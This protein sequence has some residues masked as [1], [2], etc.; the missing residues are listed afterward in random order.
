MNN[1][2]PTFT[3][4]GHPNKGK[5]S[6]VATLAQTDA[7]EISQRS[8]TTEQAHVY[9]I[10][11]PQGNLRLIDTPGFQRPY[12]ALQWLKSH[13]DNASSRAKTV[14][15]FIH[16]ETCMRLFPDEV[17]L[18]T[19]I[20]NG[21]V[22]I[23]VVDGS[24]PYG[25][26]YEFEMEIL[27]WTG[28]PSMA[29][30]NPIENE[31]HIH[32]WQDALNQYFKRVKIFNPMTAEFE[33]QVE[34][35]SIFA[36]LDDRWHT[37]LINIG[38]GLTERRKQKIAQCVA[39]L[40]QL[41]LDVCYYSV[42][43]KTINE[44]QASSITPGLKGQWEYWIKKREQDAFDGVLRIYQHHRSTLNIDQLALPPDLFDQ[45]KWYLWGLNKKQ[46][47][48]ASALA[49]AMTGATIDAATAGHSFMLGAIGGG[50]LGA[51]GSFF[52]SDKIADVS[53]KGMKVG[54]NTAIYGPVRH[55]NFPYVIL[56]R[57]IFFQQQVSSLNHANRSA[58][59][60]TAT[61]FQ[62]HIEQL[63]KSDRKELAVACARLA[64]QQTVKNLD[65]ILMTLMNIG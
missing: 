61:D 16:N 5:S 34:L 36:H 24:R 31:D 3:V 8:G 33:K 42:E 15:Q 6:I 40:E 10:T 25:A 30:I 7:I 46:L 27:R 41:L 14:E 32:E 20:V 2:S 51:G 19:P 4:V 23:Y 55:K 45:D 59:N 43:Q 64:K 35:L 53:I 22:I 37:Q 1:S 21:S 48:A 9:E 13:A 39:I 17:A 18:L 38:N 26:E 44:E 50:L 65:G 47:I 56:G 62:G 58:V 57:F 52:A 49:G 11:T 54:G 60:V 12:K 28:Q 63:Q 29:L